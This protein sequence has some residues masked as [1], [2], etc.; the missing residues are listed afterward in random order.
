MGVTFSDEVQRIVEPTLADRGF[1]LDQIDDGVDEGG[2]GLTVVYYRSHDTKLQIYD[3]VREG[4]INCMIA[5][6]GAP[7]EFGLRSPSKK[8][9]F[10]IRFVKRPDLPFE[11]LLDRERRERVSY[12]SRL[13]WVSAL[14]ESHFEEARAGVLAM[15]KPRQQ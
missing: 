14:I 15:E 7:N 6:L 5:P 8:W 1:V 4:E 13:H 12:E 2:R 9:Q 11:E 3:S 10:V